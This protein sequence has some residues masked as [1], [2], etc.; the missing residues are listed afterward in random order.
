VGKK[1][2]MRHLF[3]RDPAQK[4]EICEHLSCSQNNGGQRIF[5]DR[6]GKACLFADTPI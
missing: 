3:D 4:L 6:Y 2:S 1:V 5:G